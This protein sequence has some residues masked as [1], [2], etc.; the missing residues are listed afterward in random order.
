M[1][2]EWF[3]G[4]FGCFDDC[5]ICFVMYFCYC[6]IVGKNVEV[7]GDSCLL[8][9]LVMFVFLVNIFFMV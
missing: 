1:L 2:K 4:L 6:Y 5:G 9:G 3:Y 7:V 8:C